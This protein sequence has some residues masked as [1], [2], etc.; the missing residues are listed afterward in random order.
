MSN[1]KIASVTLK[2]GDQNYSLITVWAGKY[3]G[4]YSIALDKGSDKYPA[5]NFLDA[6]KWFAARECFVNLRIE[7]QTEQRGS[8]PRSDRRE[9]ARDDFSDDT[10]P[11]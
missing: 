5:A 3:P 9:P 4:T 8:S 11:F 6:L 7:S 1:Q 10:I 2:R